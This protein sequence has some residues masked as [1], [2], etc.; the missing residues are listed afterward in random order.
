MTFLPKSQ[1][2]KKF[3]KGNELV[4]KNNQSKSY[5]GPY[6]VTGDKR[7]FAGNDIF[8]LGAELLGQTILDEKQSREEERVSNLGVNVRKYS[9]LKP[10][11]KSKLSQTRLIP[12]SKPLPTFDDYQ[13]GYFTRYFV[14]RIN[15]EDYREVNETTYISLRKKE[16]VYDHNLYEIGRIKWYLRG[17]NIHL[18]NATQIR[19]Q[20]KQ[21][22][23]LFSLFAVL[24]E[25][26]LDEASPTQENLRTEGGELYYGDGNEYIGEYHIHPIQG[27]MVGAQHIN[28]PH[29]KLYYFNQLPV[30]SGVG[31]YEE[32]LNNYQKITCYICPP[33]KF[34][35]I[36]TIKASKFSG[37]PAGSYPTRFK[38]E[39]NCF[40]EATET[41]DREESS[42]GGGGY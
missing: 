31:S 42:G 18:K 32:F 4:Y 33:D 3:T 16:Y 29:D 41:S 34:S 10:K 39:Q 15:R 27:P 23:N 12:S 9:I 7:Y 22:P 5:K 13:R 24:N 38:A 37:C 40:N 30:P 28:G 20:E 36:N 1:Y 6:I 8:N 19:L 26:M 21:Y 17:L 2:I 35:P 14:K 11:I 25:H